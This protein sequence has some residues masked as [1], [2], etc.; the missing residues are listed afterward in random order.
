MD[1]RLPQQALS[2]IAVGQPV[3]LSADTWPGV[4][5]TGRITAVNP[6]IDSATRNVQI[7]AS[8]ENHARQL[9]PGMFGHLN[10]DAGKQVRALTLPQSAITYNPYGATV[11]LVTADNKGGQTVKQSFVTVGET[12]G[13]QVQALTGVKEGD[14]VVTA[15]QLKIKNGT[16]VAID[17]SHEPSNDPNPTPQEH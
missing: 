3:T 5:F 7:E 2:R 8:V 14:V 16:P 17:N 13:D 10:V 12:R 4:T 6:L 9:F 15:G 11:F 1:F